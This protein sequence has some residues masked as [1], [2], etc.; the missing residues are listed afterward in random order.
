MKSKINIGI[1]IGDPSGI[2][3]EVTIKALRNFK[4]VQHC[5][6]YV[7][8]DRFVLEKNGLKNNK[9]KFNLI[10]L[11][12]ADAKQF[13]LGKLSKESGWASLSYLKKAVEFLKQ[14]SI[15]CLVT[16]PVSKE[17]ISSNNIEFCGHTEFLA[18][19]FNTKKFVMMF[20]ASK[21]KLSLVTRHI[22]LKD[23]P[24]S[25][26]K[27]DI[28][29]NISLT[30][31]AL[32]DYFGIKR[33]KIAV[34]ALNPHGS[35][36]GEEEDDVIKPV[37]DKFSTTGTVYGPL[38]ADT[39]FKRVLSNEFDAVVC[40][41]HDQGLIPFK[42]LHSS[43]GVNLTLGLPF[44]RTSPVHGTAFDIAG[45]NKADYRSMLAAI[46]LAYA[47]TKNKLRN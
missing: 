25:I 22:A 43:D 33:P 8:G 28:F 42:M 40:M 20:V 37:V 15:D 2:G 27:E 14:G 21:M 7:F 31:K 41:Y 9:D 6:I 13:G 47:L 46:N 5:Q 44:I 24:T 4:A 32:K 10:D 3:P 17:A 18:K 12:I 1:T 39:I 36:I 23:V 34:S 45:K 29:T 38:P 30:Y 19:E 26:N 35:E 11:N 16:A